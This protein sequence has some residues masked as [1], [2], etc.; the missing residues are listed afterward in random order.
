M[1]DETLQA[2]LTERAVELG[3][4][5]DSPGAIV[6][7][8]GELLREKVPERVARGYWI[9]LDGRSDKGYDVRL[10]EIRPTWLRGGAL[11]LGALLGAWSG[12][13]GVELEIFHARLASA[14]GGPV[15]V[16]AWVGIGAIVPYTA[17]RDVTPAAVASI[18][19]RR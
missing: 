17:L 3:L 13:A 12:G 15:K 9:T 8:L 1:S 16:R 10:W 7:Q 18:S 14:P 19:I 6:R 11:R 2:W 5:Y 4:S